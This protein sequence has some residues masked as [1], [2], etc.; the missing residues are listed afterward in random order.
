MVTPAATPYSAQ[1]SPSRRYRPLLDMP[2][3][4]VLPAS[5]NCLKPRSRG[6]F[7]QR[8]MTTTILEIRTYGQGVTDD[9]LRKHNR[10][11]PGITH[12]KGMGKAFKRRQRTGR[13]KG[14][15]ETCYVDNEVRG[16]LTVGSVIVWTTRGATLEEVAARLVEKSH[17]YEVKTTRKVME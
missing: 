11:L 4:A 17:Q 15:F 2:V 10:H 9:L 8:N 5:L 14:I 12:D 7:S 3:D 6:W 16:I 13:M 1:R